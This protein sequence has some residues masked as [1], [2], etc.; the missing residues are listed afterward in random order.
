MP[1]L[2][3]LLGFP[4]ESVPAAARGG[5]GD[6]GELVPGGARSAGGAGIDECQCGD[7]GHEQAEYGMCVWAFSWFSFRNDIV[8]RCESTLLGQSAQS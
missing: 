5:R 8:G 3:R 7:D 6:Q 1:P 4:G 2:E